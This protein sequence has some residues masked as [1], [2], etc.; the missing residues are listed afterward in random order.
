MVAFKFPTFTLLTDCFILEDFR[1]TS[2]GILSSKLP[3][4]KERFP[5]NVRNNIIQ[6]AIIDHLDTQERR[7]HWKTNKKISH[8]NKIR[9]YIPLKN[10]T[11]KHSMLMTYSMEICTLSL[12]GCF[13]LNTSHS[14]V[15]LNNNPW[16]E[17]QAEKFS[18]YWRC[19]QKPA[20]IY[21][22]KT[23]RFQFRKGLSHTFKLFVK[24]F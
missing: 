23:K 13:F 2:V 7:P 9:V 21:V 20:T 16:M 1:V 22:K 11:R 15:P 17:P 14:K 4:I 5:V 18:V 24:Q 12:I 3:Y 19:L 8:N 6:T 10:F